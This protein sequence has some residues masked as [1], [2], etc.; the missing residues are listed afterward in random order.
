MLLIVFVTDPVQCRKTTITKLQDQDHLF[1]KD[2][3]IIN[4][5]PQKNVSW[6]KKSG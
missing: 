3:H 6:Q 4:P 2:H 5:R 1:F